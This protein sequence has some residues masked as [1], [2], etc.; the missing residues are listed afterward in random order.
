HGPELDAP[1]RRDQGPGDGG[2]GADDPW[3]GDRTGVRL[4]GRRGGGAGH[5]A[6]PG[7]AAD[8]RAWHGRV[9]RDP[10][11]AGQPDREPDGT[12]SL[13][14]TP[15]MIRTI[16]SGTR[17]LPACCATRWR[18]SRCSATSWAGPAATSVARIRPL[19]GVPTSSTAW[20]PGEEGT[21][22]HVFA[23]SAPCSWD[24][25]A[26]ADAD[27]P[28]AAARHGKPLAAANHVGHGAP[29]G[30]HAVPARGRISS[31]PAPGRALA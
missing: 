25:L 17:S 23:G 30:A 9:R 7:W 19:H 6:D 16:P 2:G 18:Q 27:S 4:A 31:H 28:R 29:R 26:R 10:T 22:H 13:S 12:W 14:Q 11:L 20:Y 3:R 1:V 24:R 8:P 15:T 5:P 21:G